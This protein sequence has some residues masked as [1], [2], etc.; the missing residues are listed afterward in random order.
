MICVGFISASC[1]FTATWTPIPNAHALGLTLQPSLSGA[2]ATACQAAC[3]ANPTCMSI[4]YNFQDMSCWFGNTSNPP[5]TVI[6][7]ITHY[8]LARNSNCKLML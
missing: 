2:G 6:A 7:N 4:D 5:T 8:N 3:F 1:T